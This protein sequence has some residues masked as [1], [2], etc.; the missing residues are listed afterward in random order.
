M[1]RGER[2]VAVARWSD[3][4][5]R[6]AGASHLRASGSHLCSIFLGE[7]NGELGKLH[8]RELRDARHQEPHCSSIVNRTFTVFHWIA[9]YNCLGRRRLVPEP[10]APQP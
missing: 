7:S 9:A 6:Y 4:L 5:E 2:S 1:P 3:M 8:G 10:R